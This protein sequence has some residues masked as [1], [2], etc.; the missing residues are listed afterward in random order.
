M[1]QAALQ[2]SGIQGAALPSGI[3]AFVGTAGQLHMPG[4]PQECMRR[5]CSRKCDAKNGCRCKLKH[6]LSSVEERLTV[7][8]QAICWVAVLGCW[9][10][11]AAWLVTP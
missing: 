1:L 3:C 10:A 11:M 9:G 6:M 8:S 2:D 4:V 7:P 5:T